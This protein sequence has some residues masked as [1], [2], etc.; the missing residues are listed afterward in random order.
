MVNFKAVVLFIE[1]LAYKNHSK[2]AY[3][4]YSKFCKRH[5]KKHCCGYKTNNPDKAGI[6]ECSFFL[7]GVKLIL[8]FMFL[9]ELI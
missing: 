8:P 5:C 2:I 9:E 3:T 6:F 1:I 7:E 4:I